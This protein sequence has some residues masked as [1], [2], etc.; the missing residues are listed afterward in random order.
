MATTY[1]DQNAFIQF[2]QGTPY[3]E[4]IR[5]QFYSY[6][7]YP[8]A[9]ASTLNFFGDAVSSTVNAQLTNMP[10]ANSFADSYFLVKSLRTSIFINDLDLLGYDGTDAS[11]VASDWLAG[12]AQA[13][14]LDFTIGSRSFFQVPKPF[15]LCAGSKEADY[16]SS[17]VSAAAAALANQKP[18]CAGWSESAFLVDP[19][20]AIEPDA[21][22]QI[23]INYPSGL[24]PIIATTP[25]T[26]ANLLSVGIELD[27]IWARKLQ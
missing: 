10:K 6:I 15:L 24:V 5:K 4:V 12:F 22:F 8:L 11:T 26:A 27:G 13:G 25:V 17:S 1:S 21:N 18:Y 16:V 9:G 20:I 2:L 23:S 19:A 7:T 3:R 14:Y